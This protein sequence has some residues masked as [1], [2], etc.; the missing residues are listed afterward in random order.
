[1]QSTAEFLY[2]HLGRDVDFNGASNQKRQLWIRFTGPAGLY[3]V[4]LTGTSVTNGRFDATL[5][6]SRFNGT[7]A[8]INRFLN[9]A[10]PGSTWDM[11]SASN[12]IAPNSY[13]WRTNWT[14]IDGIARRTQNQG[15]IGG[16]WNGSGVD[17][18]LMAGWEWMY[19]RRATA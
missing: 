14:G 2:Y 15:V 1:M 13:L 5:N 4:E 3:K 8:P 6:P 7:T 12:N 16:L 17:R 19:R 11:A 9:F 18:R 10:A